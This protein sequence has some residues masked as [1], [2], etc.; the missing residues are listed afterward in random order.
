MEIF[1]ILLFLI[2][3]FTYKKKVITDYIKYLIESQQE[4]LSYIIKTFPNVT[5]LLYT[6]YSLKYLI[7]KNLVY[8]NVVTTPLHIM[9]YYSEKREEY[10]ELTQDY[11]SFKD[12]FI[13]QLNFTDSFGR[14]VFETIVIKNMPNK[15]TF[16]RRFMLL[17]INDLDLEKKSVYENTLGELLDLAKL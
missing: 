7:N 14:T 17:F 8:E 12:A 11:S 5:Y 4:F 9:F 13:E 16:V 6:N 10:I 3:K 1:Y 2:G 15:Y